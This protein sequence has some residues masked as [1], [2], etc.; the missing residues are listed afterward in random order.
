MTESIREGVL[1]EAIENGD[2]EALIRLWQQS[3]VEKEGQALRDYISL[4]LVYL[5]KKLNL[6]LVNTFRELVAECDW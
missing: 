1:P 5:S 4:H 6:P 2:V 3:L